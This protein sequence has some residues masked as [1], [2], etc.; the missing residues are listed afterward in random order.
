MRQGYNTASKYIGSP[1]S[2]KVQ[3]LP[4]KGMCFIRVEKVRCI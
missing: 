1:M 3:E 4:L 2:T